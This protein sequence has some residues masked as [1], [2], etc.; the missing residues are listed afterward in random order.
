[1]EDEDPIDNDGTLFMEP[2]IMNEAKKNKYD[3]LILTEPI[4]PIINGSLKV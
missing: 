1:M 4:L 3:E 2:A